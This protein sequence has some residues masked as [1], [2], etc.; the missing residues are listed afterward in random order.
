MSAPVCVI[1]RL[2]F[3][4]MGQWVR[5]MLI[6]RHLLRLA[7][8]KVDGFVLA[9]KI[10]PARGVLII[11][12]LWRDDESMFRFTGLE[13]HVNAARWTL[14]VGAKVWSAVFDARGA[15]SMS[16]GWIGDLEPWIKAEV[17]KFDATR[18]EVEGCE[19]PKGGTS[20][21]RVRESA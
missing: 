6:F 14:G 19:T 9:K 16:A 4:T 12:S 3:R 1:T 2:E 20:P 11:T 5:A 21:E 7:E 13:S 15:S 8:S 10:V 17:A 18:F